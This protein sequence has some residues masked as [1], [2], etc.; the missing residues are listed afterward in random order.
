MRIGW[1]EWDQIYSKAGGS[2]GTTPVGSSSPTSNPTQGDDKST[3][4]WNTDQDA[5]SDLP[6]ASSL[7]LD[8]WLPL[9]PHDT[10]SMSC[11]LLSRQS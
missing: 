3:D 4:W 5:T 8:Q 2:D 11:L 1:Q 10:G 6:G 9:Q 7:P